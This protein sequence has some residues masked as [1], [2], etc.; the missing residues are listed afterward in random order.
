MALSLALFSSINISASFGPAI[1]AGSLSSTYQVAS[2]LALTATYH[3]LDLNYGFTK[4]NGRNTSAENLILHSFIIGYKHPLYATETKK[5]SAQ[6]GSGYH[7]VKRTLNRNSETGYGFGVRYALKYV[8]QITATRMQPSFI[9]SLI[10]DQII[11][12]RNWNSVQISSS[13]FIIKAMLGI[14]I[15]LL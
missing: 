14:Q 9:T 6:I 8:Q 7:Y 1:P 15:N 4:F 5:L 13:V 11:Q 10:T 3:R 12:T 2:A